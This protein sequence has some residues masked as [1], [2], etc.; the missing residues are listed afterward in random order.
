MTDITTNQDQFKSIADI[1]ITNAF[2]MS[3]VIL[4]MQVVNLGEGDYR[5]MTIFTCPK[6]SF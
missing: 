5:S 6:W 1:F 3:E 2:V 4:H